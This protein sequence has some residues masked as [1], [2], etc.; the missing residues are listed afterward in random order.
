MILDSS[1]KKY[2]HGLCGRGSQLSGQ[3]TNFDRMNWENEQFPISRPECAGVCQRERTEE[4][5]YVDIGLL[6][7]G[8]SRCVNSRCIE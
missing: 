6:G 8:V 5:R 3:M 1:G 2:Q 7:T 4:L